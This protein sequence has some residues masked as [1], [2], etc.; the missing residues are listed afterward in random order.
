MEDLSTLILGFRLSE[1]LRFYNIVQ[2][3]KTLKATDPTIRDFT[4]PVTFKGVSC[5]D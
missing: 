4:G 1:I 3:T 2:R 5:R